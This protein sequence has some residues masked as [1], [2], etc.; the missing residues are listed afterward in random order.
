[1]WIPSLGSLRPF[2]LY[3]LS[4]TIYSQLKPLQIAADKLHFQREQERILENKTLVVN[5]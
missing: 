2:R 3:A 1:M 5:L 4:A